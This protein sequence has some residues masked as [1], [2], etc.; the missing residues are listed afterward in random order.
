MIW[1]IC[2]RITTLII[3]SIPAY[4]KN[5]PIC[6]IFENR[7]CLASLSMRLLWMRWNHLPTSST[8]LVFHSGY[9]L[10]IC[11]MNLLY[12]SRASN[13]SSVNCF[14]KNWSYWIGF[15]F[16]SEDV[17]ICYVFLNESV[18]FSQLDHEIIQLHKDSID[19]VEGFKFQAC[20]LVF[21]SLVLASELCW[22]WVRREIPEVLAF[23]IV[24]SWIHKTS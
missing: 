18:I 14:N 1:I 15:A 22:S 19:L 16:P 24:R 6:T 20:L 11:A 7:C 10:S 13:T 8:I 12:R 4:S 5:E 17:G 9:S 23:L 21:L 3:R 2:W